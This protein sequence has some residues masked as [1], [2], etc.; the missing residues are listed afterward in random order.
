VYIAK[1]IGIIMIKKNNL[2]Y[3]EYYSLEKN[4][5]TTSIVLSLQDEHELEGYNDFAEYTIDGTLY[6]VIDVIFEKS[7]KTVLTTELYEVR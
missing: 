5:Q 6:D 1:I 7:I 2:Y 4:K 3:Y